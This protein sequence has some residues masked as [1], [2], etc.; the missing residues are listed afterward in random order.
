MACP[1]WCLFFPLL[2]RHFLCTLLLFSFLYPLSCLLFSFGS[3]LPVF[4]CFVSI[5]VCCFATFHLVRIFFVRFLSWCSPCNVLFLF[6]FCSRGLFRFPCIFSIFDIRHSWSA[7]SALSFR[8]FQRCR[9]GS[10]C[11]MS[12][13]STCLSWSFLAV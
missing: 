8:R 6:M 12:N 9:S 10:G 11:R 13:F 4:V 2:R 5:F 1:V 3:F 7:C